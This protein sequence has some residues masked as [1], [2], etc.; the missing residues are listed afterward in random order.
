MKSTHANKE[1][2]VNINLLKKFSCNDCRYTAY[3]KDALDKHIK[4]IHALP[5]KNSTFHCEFCPFSTTTR[6]KLLQHNTT[7]H[8]HAS[9]ECDQCAFISTS[10]FALDLHIVNKHD[11]TQHSQL[12]HLE[13]S[14][15]S[16]EEPYFPLNHQEVPAQ[17]SSI[18]SE[19]VSEKWNQPVIC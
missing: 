18:L 1:A 3:Q 16:K 2:V 9:L 12:N 10:Q 19:Y 17:D 15:P 11:P 14:T 13:D 5:V 7:T 4:E 6:T 8:A